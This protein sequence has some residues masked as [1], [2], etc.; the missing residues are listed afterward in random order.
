MINQKSNNFPNKPQKTSFWDFKSVKVYT[1]LGEK[2][3]DF[4]IGF[5][6]GG[7]ILNF[8]PGY[9]LTRFASLR[10]KQLSE[11]GREIPVFP[12]KEILLILAIYV[13]VILVF[14]YLWK[15]RRHFALGFLI[16]LIFS[17]LAFILL[18]H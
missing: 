7:V 11:M 8:T 15:R 1:D 4:V 14:L 10:Y 6:I 5:I 17:I 3:L 16:P 9:F 13:V 2:I 12:I 18:L